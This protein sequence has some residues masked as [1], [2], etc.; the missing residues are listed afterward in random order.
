MG[1]ILT[2]GNRKWCDDK[3]LPVQFAQGEAKLKQG[4]SGQ[5]SKKE[6]CEL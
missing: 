1:E 2:G 6:K 4:F 5:Q 3:E